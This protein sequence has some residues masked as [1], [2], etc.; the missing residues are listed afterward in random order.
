MSQTTEDYNS[1]IGYVIDRN[2]S[3]KLTFEQAEKI[4]KYEQENSVHSYK[5]YFSEWETWDYEST[6]FREI[7]TDEQFKKYEKSLKKIIKRYEASLIEE[8]LASASKI[9]YYEDAIHFYET[10]LLPE[11]LRHPV[12]RLDWLSN[13]RNKVEYLRA[14]YKSYLI[15]T[16]NEILTTHFRNYRNFKPNELKA[17]LLEHKIRYIFPDYYNFKYKMDILTK[18]IVDFLKIELRYLTNELEGFFARIIEAQNEFHRSNDQKHS[19]QR[20]GWFFAVEDQD[21][22]EE[23][24]HLIMTLLLITKEKYS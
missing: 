17:S 24:E 15:E 4:Y 12:M 1:Q 21:S 19:N 10:E 16:K 14:E 11:I 2:Y 7:L 20:T 6:V 5:H 3:L 8:D 18:T 22:G 9:P 23:K 13:K